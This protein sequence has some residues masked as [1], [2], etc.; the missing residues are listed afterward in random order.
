MS[1][2]K[3]NGAEVSRLRLC[4]AMQVWGLANQVSCRT[5]SCGGEQDEVP[6]SRLLEA[7]AASAS[8]SRLRR[9]SLRR[10]LQ[11]STQLRGAH[12]QKPICCTGA[13]RQRHLQQ[14]AQHAV[15]RDRNRFRGAHCFTYVPQNRADPSLSLVSHT[16]QRAA[17]AHANNTRRRHADAL[18]VDV[19][20]RPRTACACALYDN[21]L[22]P[23]HL[24]AVL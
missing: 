22:D 1:A 14:P 18:A 23:V 15:R 13:T 24:A 8:L 2:D 6:V 16:Q 5:L 4:L 3:R 17:Q 20:G 11:G 12:L 19:K 7:G 21:G 9:R 10:A